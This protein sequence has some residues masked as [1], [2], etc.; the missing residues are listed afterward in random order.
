MGKN[1]GRQAHPLIEIQPG[2]VKLMTDH[3]LFIEGQ[4]KLAHQSLNEI[5]V[6]LLSRGA[7]PRYVQLD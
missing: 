7:P 6:P 4:F 3:L 1:R 5:P 2:L